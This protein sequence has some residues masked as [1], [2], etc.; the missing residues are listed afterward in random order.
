MLRCTKSALKEPLI[1]W[2]LPAQGIGC[3]ISVHF[4][5]FFKN[6]NQNILVCFVMV[7]LI[8]VPNKNQNVVITEQHYKYENWALFSKRMTTF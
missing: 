1:E 3:C 6:K 4:K 8:R 2:I 7:V 5:F